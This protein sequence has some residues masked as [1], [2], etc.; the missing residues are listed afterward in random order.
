VI[1]VI[2]LIGS[3]GPEHRI[4]T[5]SLSR[6]YCFLRALRAQRLSKHTKRSLLASGVVRGSRN[7]DNQIRI[8]RAVPNRL[9]AMFRIMLFTR[10]RPG[11]SLEGR[12]A[13]SIADKIL[14]NFLYLPYMQRPRVLLIHSG[15]RQIGFRTRKRAHSLP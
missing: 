9:S 7:R 11:V 12:K 14:I 13:R 1:N 6:P 10:A 4:H 8:R 2:K 3:I 5:N 15:V